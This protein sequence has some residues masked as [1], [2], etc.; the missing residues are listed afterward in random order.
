[1]KVKKYFILTLIIISIVFNLNYIYSN[2]INNDDGNI[3]IILDC[4]ASMNDYIDR[5]KKISRFD[6]IRDHLN[7]L[8]SKSSNREISLIVFGAY[9][10]YYDCDDYKLLVEPTTDYK[11]IKSMIN[12]LNPNGGTPLANTISFAQEISKKY[13]IKNILIFTDGYES[14]S[15]LNLKSSLSNLEDDDISCSILGVGLNDVDQAKFYKNS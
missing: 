6:I 11:K 12:D 7:T 14:C 15:P 9:K 4:S 13:N 2:N 1:M 8:L 10:G 5:N 3:L